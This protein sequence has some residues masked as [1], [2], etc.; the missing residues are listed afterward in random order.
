[1]RDNSSRPGSVALAITLLACLALAVDPDR[2]ARAQQAA[3][4]GTLAGG[5]L[6]KSTGDPIIEAGVE[7]IGTGKT[8]RTD[9]DGRYTV[10]LPPGSYQVRI[11]AP[12]YKGTRLENVAV[13]PGAVT[14]ADATLIGEGQAGGAPFMLAPLITWFSPLLR[15]RE[16]PGPQEPVGTQSVSEEMAGE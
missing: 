6:D 16:L 14:K 9:L 11:F 12:L 4:V 5:V 15:M 2:T 13:R 10:K 8:V 3:E 1:M 7:V